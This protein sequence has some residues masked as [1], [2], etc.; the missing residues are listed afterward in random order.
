MT[1]GAGNEVINSDRNQAI[2]HKTYQVCDPI[3]SNFGEA[4]LP[5]GVPRSLKKSRVTGGWGADVL[6]LPLEVL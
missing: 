3:I 5:G 4:N 6:S 2:R 1:R